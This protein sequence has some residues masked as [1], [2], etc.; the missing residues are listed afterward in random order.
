[1][2]MIIYYKRKNL[3]AQ[4]IYGIISLLFGIT[5]FIS[6]T[7][8]FFIIAWL[9]LGLVQIGTWYYK[10][11]YQY[12]NIEENRLTKNALFPKSVAF[13][14]LSAIRKYKNSFL[15]ES[16]NQSIRIHKD[17]IATDSF[18]KLTDLLN[19]IELKPQQAQA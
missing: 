6:D 15:L 8:S 3:N 14:E 4:L 12:L 9:L 11:K 2:S 19:K 17:I 10:Q 7:K 18:Y 13:N 16:K 1:M 5:G